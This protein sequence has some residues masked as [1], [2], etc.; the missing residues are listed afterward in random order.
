[1]AQESRLFASDKLTDHNVR[2]ICQDKYGYIW[3]GTRSGLNKFDGY[4]FT[5]YR[6]HQGD[7]AL[8]SNYDTYRNIGLW[9][10]H[11]PD[12]T[13]AVRI[14]DFSHH[15]H[16]DYYFQLLIDSKKRLWKVDKSNI[17]SC[18]NFNRHDF[19]ASYQPNLGYIIGIDETTNGDI[20]AV[21]KNGIYR[22]DC[23][24]RGGTLPMPLGRLEFVETHLKSDGTQTCIIHTR[25]YC[26]V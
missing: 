20:L 10:I 26:N 4:R 8:P 3:I 1:M 9:F 7:K 15:D 14:N 25:S 19:I 17:I 23:D 13:V 16:N 2:A 11:N 5:A 12:S 21:C 18:Y 6:H 24:G 22:I